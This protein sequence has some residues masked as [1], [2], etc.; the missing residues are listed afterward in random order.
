MEFDD[1]AQDTSQS[2]KPKPQEHVLMNEDSYVEDIDH[3]PDESTKSPVFETRKRFTWLE[4][5]LKEDEGHVITHGTSRESNK[6]KKYSG[7]TTLMCK[8]IKSKSS[9]Y[10]EVVEDQVWKEAMTIKSINLY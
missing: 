5:T 2:V 10:E 1:E 6:P 3:E 9:S 8:I 7:Y 4:K